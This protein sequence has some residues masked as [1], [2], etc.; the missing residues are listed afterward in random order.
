MRAPLALCILLLTALSGCT[1]EPAAPAPTD[2]AG[3]SHELAFAFTPARP[4]VDEPVQ[5]QAAVQPAAAFSSIHWDFDDGTASTQE[6]PTH[7]FVA[8]GR[9]DVTVTAAVGSWTG[10]A[11]RTVVVSAP[12][13]E[14]PEPEEVPESEPGPAPEPEEAPITDT[15]TS[16][17]RHLRAGEAAPAPFA[18]VATFDTGANPFHPTWRVPDKG[19]PATFI[20]GYPSESK[21][22]NLTLGPTFAASWQS[23][24]GTMEQLLDH[25]VP[26][27]YVPGTRLVGLWSREGDHRPIFDP[28]D[29]THYH[30]ARASSQ[31]AGEGYGMADEA[32]VA[33][34]DRT[35]QNA[36]G[37]GSISRTAGVKWAADQPW[38]DVIHLNVAELAPAP[39]V[40]STFEEIEYATE[41]GKLVVV[42]GGNGAGNAGANYPTEAS[43]V[44][45]PPGSLVAGANDNCGYTYYSNLNPHVV[46]DGAGTVA[47]HEVEFENAGF[48]GTSS[49]SPRIAG[50]ATALLL[51]L[52]RE[53]NDHHGSRDRALLVLDDDWPATGPLADG[54]LDVAELHEVIRKTADPNPHP[55]RYDGT[56]Y[57]PGMCIPQP[58]DSPQ[59]VYAK[60]GYGEVSEHTFPHA[61]AVLAGREP[62]PE[63][64]DEDRWYELSEQLRE[65]FWG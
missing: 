14:P 43:S 21:P 65:T 49:S 6:T 36:A 9:Y 24:Q 18:V 26:L 40:W 10:Q 11:T 41:R 3:P 35:Q 17:G 5:F 4:N 32:F 50:Y 61:L 53:F 25:S 44:S 15:P 38:V 56:S 37:E 52:R 46:M 54:R 8:P 63:R 7:T 23:S 12:G 31:I 2:S 51:E 47:A 39:G 60:M 19:H 16:P 59:A 33:I 48:S 64:P 57:V 45:G 29:A 58:V 1:T 22:L 28:V 30:G 42:A 55:S 62:M 13:Q 20:P 27:H 34:F